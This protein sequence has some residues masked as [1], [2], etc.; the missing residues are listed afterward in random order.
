M[1]TPDERGADGATAYDELIERY[2]QY[3]YLQH[4]EMVVMWDQQV[5]MPEGGAPAR[6]KQRGALSTV[7]HDRLTDEAIGDLLN[8][9]DEGELDDDQRAVVRE[10]RRDYERAAGVPSDLVTR[11]SEY[12]AENHRIWNEAKAADDYDDFAPR[13]DGMVDLTR[14]RSAAIDSARD[15][16]EVQYEE[17]QPYLPLDRVEEVFAEL[18]DH[19]VP[20]IERIRTDG[21]EIPEVVTGTY[22]AETQEELCR[23]ALDT[24]GYDWDRGRLDTAPHPFMAGTQFDARVTTRYDES[25]PLA[26]LMAV[27]HEYGHASY[28]QGLRQDA[29]G[30][31]LGSPR[32]SGVHESQSRFWE[33]HVG[34]TKPFWELFLPIVKEHFPSLSDLTVDDAYAAVNRIYP[35]NC[36]RV[37]ADELTYHM[38][39]ILRCEIDSALVRGELDIED[40]PE[41]WNR[42]ME[43]YLSVVPDTDAEG[44]LQD[45][46]WSMGLASFHG[47]TV[48]SVLAAQLDAALREDLDVDGLVREG[49]FDPIREWMTEHVHRHGKRYPTDELIEEATGEPLSAEYFLDYVDEKFADLYDL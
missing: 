26:G 14:E 29:Y 36:I 13:L 2:R 27:I 31:P 38:H 12:T 35:E 4:A 23:A 16:Y 45:I 3:Q 30:S 37:E 8:R 9:I 42:K 22:D 49:E 18:R 10:I 46:H 17:R 48:G 5:M 32:S 15:P 19:L 39:I 24:V 25:S 20:L 33:N 7:G 6:A 40:V 28:Q 44:C 41:V 47:Y 1:A 43:E 34:R 11:F 21:R